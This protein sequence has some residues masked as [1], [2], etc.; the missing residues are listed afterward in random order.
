MYIRNTQEASN[1]LNHKKSLTISCS[2][3]TTSCLKKQ[4]GLETDTKLKKIYDQDIQMEFGIEKCAHKLKW[5]KTNHGRNRTVKSKKE[6][7]ERSE[8]GKTTNSWKN[9]KYT[10]SNKLC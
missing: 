3:L 10:L 6:K 8:K 4:Q 2:W 7:S 5:E 9:C 1:L